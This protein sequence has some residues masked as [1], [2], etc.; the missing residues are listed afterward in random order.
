MGQTSWT[1]GPSESHSDQRD[2]GS[3]GGKGRTRLNIVPLDLRLCSSLRRRLQPFIST[4]CHSAT[5]KNSRAS[6]H[7]LSSHFTL[8]FRSPFPRQRSFHRYAIKLFSLLFPSL[9][10]LILFCLLSSHLILITSLSFYFLYLGSSYY[11]SFLPPSPNS[12]LYNILSLGSP[13]ARP[14]VVCRLWPRQRRS[15]LSGPAKP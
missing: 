11:A 4:Q 14:F 15:D 3:L 8:F 2:S 5:F 7:I 13:P 12:S 9:L 1:T 6:F 10:H